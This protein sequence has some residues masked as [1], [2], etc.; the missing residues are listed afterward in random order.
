MIGMKREG[1][2]LYELIN[3]NDGAVIKP[4]ALSVTT[5]FNC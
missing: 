5:V 2:L 1:R 4:G 3:P